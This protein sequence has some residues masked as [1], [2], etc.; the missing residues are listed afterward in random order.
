MSKFDVARPPETL[1]IGDEPWN[2]PPERLPG[3][4]DFDTSKS[5]LA[6]SQALLERLRNESATAKQ[7]ADIA[8]SPATI[9][10]ETG[11]GVLNEFLSGPLRAARSLVQ[12]PTDIY[13]AMTGKGVDTSTM[14]DVMDNPYQTYQG[15]IASGKPVIPEVGQAALDVSTFL[16]LGKMAQLGG[17]MLP[18]TAGIISS[19]SSPVVKPIA[20]YLAK[21]AETKSVTTALKSVTP[22]TKDL[23]TVEYQTLLSKKRIQPKT[24]LKA[25][26]YILSE[27]EK[28]AAEKY[29]SLLQDKD[30]VKNTIS[31]RN[32]LAKEDADVGKFLSDNNG[33]FNSGELRNY[34]SKEMEDVSDV[35]VP[36][37]RVTKLKDQITTN[38]LSSLKKNDM[39]SLWKGR[40]EFDYAI[41]KAFSGSPTLTKEVKKKFRNAVQEYIS[42]NTPD[43]IYKA[44]MKD[45]TDL[46]NLEEVLQTKAVKE[47]GLTGL[48]EWAKEHPL[49][50]GIVG[51]SAGAVG[52]G[53]IWN[54]VN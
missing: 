46:Y 43:G 16:P 45:M 54:T 53:V 4:F 14:P 32:Q 30:P 48:Q 13:N 47:K 22:K 3:D 35:M 1:Q 31:V 24:G 11:K 36:E 28:A 38:F 39:V 6:H 7:A 9:A 50:A 33:I 37:E 26:Q 2:Q 23:T 15:A 25:P 19:V 49:E 40:K 10:K 52:G 29:K 5:S 8:Q 17:K 42:D 44:K 51:A 34:I 12:A 20:N 41:E 18:K 27:R 21:R